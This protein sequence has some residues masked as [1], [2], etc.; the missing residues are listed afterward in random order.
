M[1]NRRR[2]FKSLTSTV[3]GHGDRALLAILVVLASMPF[4]RLFGNY[5]FLRMVCGAVLVTLSVSL[6]LS[7]RRPLA[8]TAG[9]SG[10][11]IFA[12]L[13]VVVFRVGVPTPRELGAVWDGATGSWARLLTSSLPAPTSARLVALPVLVAWGAVLLGV[14]MSIRRRWTSAPIVGPLVAF[15]VALSFAGR[16]PA[17]S[18]LLPL[19]L[20]VVALLVVL[21]R[22][23]RAHQEG[24]PRTI[25]SGGRRDGAPG[26][27]ADYLRLGFPIIGVVSVVATVAAPALP[28]AS[29]QS[30][31]DL[32]DRYR[33]P[34]DVADDVSPLARVGA[35]IVDESSDPLFSV[36][37]RDVPS[38]MNIDRVRVAVLDT[39][40]GTV[41]GSDAEFLRAGRD[42]PPGPASTAPTFPIRQEYEISRWN[43]SF[44]PALDRPTQIIGQDLG[45]DRDSGMIAAPDAQPEGLR[46]VVLSDVID[47]SGVDKQATRPGNDP[48]VST[49]ALPP[50]DGWPSGITAAAARLATPTASDSYTML[51]A[52]ETKLRSADFGYDPRSRPGH[53]LGL[54][55]QF[56]AVPADASQPKT[57]QVGQAEQYAA[58]FA[59]LARVSGLPSRVVVGY[60]VDPNA[61]RKGATIDVRSSDVL[62]WPEVN[63]NGVGWVSFDPTNTGE[64]KSVVPPPTLPPVMTPTT[65]PVVP[66][67]GPTTS[68]PV[69]TT[70]TPVGG[71]RATSLWPLALALVVLAAAPSLVLLCKRVRR[72][73]RQCRGSTAERVMGAWTE[74]G[75]RL[76]SHGIGVERSMTVAELAQRCGTTADPSVAAHVW[77]FAPL[78]DLALF[79]PEEPPGSVAESAWDA[80]AR[81]TETLRERSP[82]LDRIRVALDPRPLV[83]RR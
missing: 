23:N 82:K 62:A 77:V 66:P 42:L 25:S 54:L 22:A 8:V 9:V 26:R 43:S 45:Y 30:R 6:V 64:R 80:E 67:T 79:A 34:I 65:P 4:G 41:W 31:F 52:L 74:A 1:R 78:V 51:K 7:P 35:G 29:E 32:H 76:R 69:T 36:R 55:T 75:D 20:V 53:N 10:L 17:G 11:A 40:D 50:P 12:Y 16:R 58:A 60:K 61:V 46:Y 15:T 59:I 5:G 49:A 14:E 3:S 72:R 81:L 83:S 63:L 71:T 37:I 19:S 44:L 48:K 68:T 24:Q 39:Y 47:L 27:V 18:M 56:L 33:P 21:V 13:A 38:S 73:R 57:S 70:V 28:F 2:S